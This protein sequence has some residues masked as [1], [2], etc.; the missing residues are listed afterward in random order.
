VLVK[1]V[2]D[3]GASVS[4][5]IIKQQIERTAGEQEPAVRRDPEMPVV[6]K[7]V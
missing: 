4:F 2:A 1:S 6:F 3:D 5:K 7:Y